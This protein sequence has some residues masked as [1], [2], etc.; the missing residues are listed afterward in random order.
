MTTK[1]AFTLPAEAVEG[2]SE[3]ILLG[4]FNNWNPEKAPRLERQSDG[5][6]KAVAQLEEG[7]T[8]HY[9][10]LLNDGRWINDYNAQDYINIPG[11][12]IDNCVITVPVSQPKE[13]KTV[14]SSE[15]SAP[16]KKTIKAKAEAKD[17]TTKAVTTK[18]A[19][20]KTKALEA[21][22]LIAKKAK[23]TSKKVES[24]KVEKSEKVAKQEAPKAKK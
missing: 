12:Y 20:P 21:D 16:D 17:K 9:R 1:I 4:D 2:A 18:K 3:A 7:Q 5:S 15:A 11:L 6:F 10:F 13:N 14:G 24:K 23:A 22:T 19:A 8:Y